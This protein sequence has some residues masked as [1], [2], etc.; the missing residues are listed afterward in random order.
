M[1]IPMLSS[2][3]EKGHS[4]NTLQKFNIKEKMILCFMP[5]FLVIIAIAAFSLQSLDEFEKINKDIVENDTVLIQ[6]TDRMKDNLLAQ[7][8]YARRHL[9]LG[10]PKMLELFWQRDSA[11]NA[12]VEQVRRLPQSY[13]IPI[14]QLA[15]LHSEFNV[16]YTNTFKMLANA[17]N[18]SPG[19]LDKKVFGELDKMILL[20]RQ[21]ATIAQ[22]NQHRKMLDAGAIGVRTFRTTAF[23]SLLGVLLGLIAA[24]LITRSISRSLQQLKFSTQMIAEGKFTHP[25]KIET[26]DE[27]GDLARSFGNMSQR[28]AHLEETHLDSSPLTRLPGGTAIENV[29]K[30]R[31]ISG[32]PIAFCLFD[33]D[34]FKAFNDRYGYAYGNKIIKATAQLIKS[35]VIKHAS[36]DNFVGH[37][38]GDDFAVIVSSRH[39]EAICR[40]IIK[41]FDHMVLNFYNSKDRKK[42]YIVGNTRQGLEVRFPLMTISIA[43]VA[44]DG[45]KKINYIEVGEIAAELKEHAK[46][47]A[48]SIYVVNRRG[49]EQQRRGF[50]PQIVGKGRV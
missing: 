41:D 45:L 20:I 21:M 44:T 42:G 34:N 13:E 5:I 48:G 40:T 8:A 4:M 30:S 43:V 14:E 18:R 7:E 27:F 10:S 6:A 33:L 25:L 12:L 9:I 23:L 50:Q 35:S 3:R 17:G 16:I 24:S 37:I 39:Y 11:F 26:K 47:I 36:K 15:S 22:E 19:Q 28:L 29:L 49:K 31:L 38:G 32:K 2:Y 46:S 1:K